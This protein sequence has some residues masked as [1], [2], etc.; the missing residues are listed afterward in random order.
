LFISLYHGTPLEKGTVMKGSFLIPLLSIAIFCGIASA[1]EPQDIKDAPTCMH[2]NMKRA[3]YAHTR[4]LIEYDDGTQLGA[5]SIYCAAIDLAINLDKTPKAI[6]VGDYYSK[7]LIDAEAAYWVIG[8]TKIGVMTKR[9]K[10]AFLRKK[11]AEH[12]MSQNGGK[13]GAFDDALKA[14]YEDMYADSK[15]IRGKRRIKRMQN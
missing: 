9:G 10:W 5:C 2:C 15:M 1:Q 13:M 4:V 6:R 12:F 8:G 7:A 14:T 3:Q 11:D